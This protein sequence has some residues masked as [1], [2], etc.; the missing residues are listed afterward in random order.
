V[1]PTALMSAPNSSYVGVT[2]FTV[3]WSG[4]DG[5]GESG[6]VNYDVQVKDVGFGGWTNWKTPHAHHRRL[7][8]RERPHVQF[9]TVARDAAGNVRTAGCAGLP[10]ADDH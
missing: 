1:A 2:T 4:V 5:T 3:A 10:G 8:R 9:R 6:L 7:C